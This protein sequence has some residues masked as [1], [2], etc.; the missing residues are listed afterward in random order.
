MPMAIAHEILTV[1]LNGFGADPADASASGLTDAGTG[2][3]HGFASE[4]GDSADGIVDAG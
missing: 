1:P 2:P 4:G 3:L